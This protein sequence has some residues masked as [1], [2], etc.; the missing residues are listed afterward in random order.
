MQY[1]R[2]G[3]EVCKTDAIKQIRTAINNKRIQKVPNETVTDTLRGVEA[4]KAFMNYAGI[5][6]PGQNDYVDN[7]V[8]THNFEF[9]RAPV[10]WDRE[11]TRPYEKKIR[12]GES[13]QNKRY[14]VL[15][16]SNMFQF[17]E[18]AAAFDRHGENCCKDIN[19][20]IRS[21]F[22]N[23]QTH[24]SI[25]FVITAPM[26]RRHGRS[27]AHRCTVLKCVVETAVPHLTALF[28]ENIHIHLTHLMDP[29]EETIH[30]DESILIPDDFGC[31]CCA[32][33]STSNMQTYLESSIQK[34]LSE[35]SNTST[36][37]DAWVID[38]NGDCAEL[39]VHLQKTNLIFF[40]GGETHWLQRQLRKAEFK[41]RM[42]EIALHYVVGGY[43]AGVINLGASTRF[44]AEKAILGFDAD[45]LQ[46]LNTEKGV[47]V[48]NRCLRSLGRAHVVDKSRDL[49]FCDHLS[50]DYGGLCLL[51]KD[52]FF[53]PH[54]KKVYED[55]LDQ[56]AIR[57]SNSMIMYIDADSKRTQWFSSTAPL[58]N[59][60]DTF[61]ACENNNKPPTQ[62]TRP[63]PVLSNTRLYHDNSDDSHAV[64]AFMSYAGI[65]LPEKRIHDLLTATLRFSVFD[66]G[67]H[68]DPPPHDTIPHV[69]TR[70]HE[71]GINS[72]P[73]PVFVAKNPYKFYAHHENTV[74]I[75]G[76]I[77][78]YLGKR[79]WIVTCVITACL[80]RRNGRCDTAQRCTALRLVRELAEPHLK[81]LI[82]QDIEV[83]LTHLMDPIEEAVEEDATLPN[84]KDEILAFTSKGTMISYLGENSIVLNVNDD[85]LFELYD[86][87][88]QTDVMVFLGGETLW[89]Q[90]Q[91]SKSALPDII[92]D[93]RKKHKLKKIV[94]CGYGA[95]AINLGAS[96]LYASED[97]MKTGDFDTLNDLS[98]IRG[99]FVGSTCIEML[100]RKLL[101]HGEEMALTACDSFGA[102]HIGLGLLGDANSISLSPRN[103]TYTWHDHTMCFIH[104]DGQVT[105]WV[106]S[107]GSVPVVDQ[108]VRGRD[109]GHRGGHSQIGIRRDAGKAIAIAGLLCVTILSA[110]LH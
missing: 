50:V 29:K 40:M 99:D 78:K 56:N 95:G 101:R 3:K 79:K 2:G 51:G 45:D 16:S 8:K 83:R 85:I 91:L 21:Q 42:E 64:R 80:P 20:I 30:D 46:D 55:Y 106:S 13:S 35:R 49:S 67:T 75:Q 72:L 9:T 44:T 62:T 19:C 88:E 14:P 25:M 96:T 47:F 105:R 70:D 24:M 12:G 18:E 60:D 39:S 73:Y 107:S 17:F 11:K 33:D 100:I 93:F 53:V 109:S 48:G 108:N 57:L 110:F 76:C 81:T 69:A 84:F 41:K 36:I 74:S 4:V 15:A 58:S 52:T 5:G 103:N 27:A 26:H 89:L 7:L 97:A 28:G 34:H 104:T 37:C 86:A 32:F 94:F 82:G 92:D 77:E 87:V 54:Y 68:A 65:S 31:E 59:L 22:N 10:V 1:S 98:N 61:F 6:F 63:P 23:Q 90:R 38:V 102:H 66:A 43:S 71:T